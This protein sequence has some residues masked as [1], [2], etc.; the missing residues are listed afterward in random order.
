MAVGHTKLFL[1][2][3]SDELVE[4]AARADDGGGGRG[5]LRAGGAAA[6]R[7]PDDRDAA[8][9]GSRRWPGVE[10]GDRDAFGLKL[11]PGGRGGPGLPDARRPGDRADRARLGAGR[12]ARRRA[13]RGAEARQRRVR[14]AA[15][16]AA[17]VLRRSAGA[18]GDPPAD[19]ASAIRTPRCSRAGCRRTAGHRVRLDGP[20]G[21]ARSAGCSTSRRAMPRS[22]TRRAS[23]RTSR[24]TTTRSRRCAPCSRCPAVPRRI[25]CFDISTIQGGRDRRVDGGLRGR[26][27]EA[28][29]IPEVPHPGLGTR[30]SALGGR[31]SCARVATRWSTPAEPTPRHRRRRS[32]LE[33]APRLAAPSASDPRRAGSRARPSARSPAR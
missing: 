10:L 15:G 22:P 1:E 12:D 2:G 8:A 9:R 6:R 25:E 7:D 3:R 13:G 31:R 33:R 27:D 23:T 14:R 4:R 18:A 16:G 20:A 11:G 32:A 28:V 19:R 21:A 30:G 26:P 29:G 5:A 24:R 17:A